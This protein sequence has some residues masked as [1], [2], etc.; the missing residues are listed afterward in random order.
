M[1]KTKQTQKTKEILKKIRQIEIKTS[2]IVNDI[3][4][5]QYSSAFKGRGMEFSEI[6]EYTFGDDIR[7][8]DWNVTA[9]TAKAH[10]KKFVEERE[11]SVIIM[12]DTSRSLYFGSLDK[13]KT[14]VAAEIAAILAFSAIKNNDKV[15]LIMF[16][17]KIEKFIAPKKGRQHI[18]R[19]IREIL[20]FEP[21]N[22]RTSLKVAFD[23]LNQVMKRSSV[24]FMLSDF[25]DTNY[26]KQIKITNKKHDL[27][28]I[29]ITDMHEKKL[30]KVGY[31]TVRDNETGEIVTVNTSSRIFRKTFFANIERKEQDFEGFIK[32]NAL[33]LVNVCTTDS[34]INEL[35][36]FFRKRS[37]LR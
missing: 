32:R 19:L 15:G 23:Y 9:R 22:A 30:P 24:V 7:N 26:E 4:A 14:E 5:G 10:I 31:L 6:R 11:L 2:R 37:G 17:D 29:K 36:C 27:I 13:L 18:L 12:L 21:D 8:I 28:N 20:Y 33:Q 3:F 16:S 34:Y 35:I 25:A 1:K